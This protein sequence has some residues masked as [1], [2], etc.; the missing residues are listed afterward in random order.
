MVLRGRGRCRQGG[1]RFH[2]F[3]SPAMAKARCA[4]ALKGPM[5]HAVLVGGWRRQGRGR[6][7]GRGR[8][9]TA[10]GAT[11]V[12][13]SMLGRSAIASCSQAARGKRGGSRGGGERAVSHQQ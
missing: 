7:W 12:A 1:R 9:S 2:A 11:A 10:T 3:H 5:R 6:G 8:G 4:A 13:V